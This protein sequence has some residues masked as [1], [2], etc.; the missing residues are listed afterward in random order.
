MSETVSHQSGFRIS[1]MNP[2]RL[3]ERAPDQTQEGK[4]SQTR[5]TG[6]SLIEEVR[7]ACCLSNPQ[8]WLVTDQPQENVSNPSGGEIAHSDL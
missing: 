8:A 2:P 7:G 3:N 5:L 1:Q 6:R 4:G